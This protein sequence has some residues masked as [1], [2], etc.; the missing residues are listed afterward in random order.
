ME[1][2]GVKTAE[3]HKPEG[4]LLLPEGCKQNLVAALRQ[5]LQAREIGLLSFRD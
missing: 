3:D 2:T 4:R 5:E 1:P